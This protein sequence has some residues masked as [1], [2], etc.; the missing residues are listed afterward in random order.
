MKDYAKEASELKKLFS[1]YKKSAGTKLLDVACGTG[2]H[3]KHLK[4]KYSCTGIDVNKEILKIAKK[5]V[6]DVEFIQADMTS[7][8]LERKF[9]I[10]ICMFSSI[11]YVRTYQ[12]LRKT[13]QNFSEHLVKG[14]IALVEPWFTKEIYDVGRPFMTIYDNED[15]KIARLNTS[16]IRDN[17]SVMDMH[18][19]IAERDKGVRHYVDRHELGLFEVDETLKIM[20][21]SGFE[22]QFISD[23]SMPSRGLYVGIKT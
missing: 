17:L 3:I 9:D 2:Q 5:N 13:F 14:G 1:K 18:Y 23:S 6:D 8:N 12:N 7:F 19:L 21:Y 11:G 20:R 22:S 10:I 15:L 16:E 4:D